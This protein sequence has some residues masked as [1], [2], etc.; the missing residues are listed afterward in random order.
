[1][2]VRMF[3]AIAAT[4]VVGIF[5]ASA[6]AA[7]L[8]KL[9]DDPS[10]DATMGCVADSELMSLRYAITFFQAESNYQFPLAEDIAFFTDV[11][12][13]DKETQL[14]GV[15]DKSAGNDDGY[16]CVR[17]SDPG[18]PHSTAQVVDNNTKLE[19]GEEA[20]QGTYPGFDR[21]LAH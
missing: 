14:P 9:P 1:M 3:C 2:R 4:A 7:P 11:D 16:L 5:A 13:P 12:D 19:E 10:D 6:A 21:K 18:N 20:L 15:P 17:L 8:P